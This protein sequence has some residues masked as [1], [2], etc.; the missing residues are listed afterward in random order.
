LQSRPVNRTAETVCR[1]DGRLTR[2]LRIGVSFGRAARDV[3]GPLPIIA[4]GAVL[5]LNTVA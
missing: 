4:R 1:T 2:R 5:L 3:L